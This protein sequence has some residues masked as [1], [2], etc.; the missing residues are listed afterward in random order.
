M[1]KL[2]ILIKFDNKYSKQSR[3]YKYIAKIF[4]MQFDTEEL[5]FAQA[6]LKEWNLGTDLNNTS[7]ALGVCVLSKRMDF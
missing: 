3:S 7:A 5:N 2:L 4:E 6:I 1:K